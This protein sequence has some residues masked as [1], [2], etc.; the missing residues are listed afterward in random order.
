MGVIVEW[1]RFR[2]VLSNH[3]FEEGK[4]SLPPLLAFERLLLAMRKD[5]GHSNRGIQIGDVLVRLDKRHTADTRA[6]QAIVAIIVRQVIGR[7]C[8]AGD[9]DIN[10]FIVSFSNHRTTEGSAVG[11]LAL[12][13]ASRS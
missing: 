7:S 1:A 8:R 4:V 9:I 2:E 13:Q 11:A 5:L 12:G 3:A 10:R 6:T